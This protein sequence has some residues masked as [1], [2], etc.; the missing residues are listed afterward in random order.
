MRKIVPILLLILSFSAVVASGFVQNVF[1]MGCPSPPAPTC[2]LDAITHVPSA[3]KIVRVQVGASDG[4]GTYNLNQ[5]F[6]YANDTSHT[7][8]VLD[9]SFIGTASGMRYTFSGW[10]T[11]GPSGWFQFDSSPTMAVGPIYTNYTVAQC[12]PGP[13]GQN[14][15]FV[16]V[17]SV[18]PPLGCKTKCYLD[19]LTNVPTADGSVMVRVDSN[20]PV[21]LSQTFAFPN[22]TVHTI[23]VLNLTFTGVSS[24]A[25]YVWKQWSCACSDIPI[26]GS[27]TLTTPKMY[28]NDTN[29][30]GPYLNGQGA[31]TAV[32]DKQFQLTLNFLDPASPAQPVAP[33]NWLTIKNGN[34]VLNL[35]SYS[36]QWTSA[37]LWTVTDAKWEGVKGMARGCP[38][39]CPTIDLTGGS[40][41]TAITLNAYVASIKIV[42]NANNLVSGATVIVVLDNSTTKTFTTDSSGIVQLGHVPIGPYSVQVTYQNQNVGNWQT[43]ASN[44]ATQPL[45]VTVPVGSAGGGNSTAVSSI[46]L[47]TIFGL[48]LFLILLAIKVRKAPPAPK[49]E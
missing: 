48:A 14:C 25:K 49:I 16:A 17:F 42:D 26:T 11:Y 21:S 9:T 38:T 30:A 15:P 6:S 37:L 18:S 20:S 39:A 4:G 8:T 47:L 24:G 31:L 45:I 3:D 2:K 32:F 44:P 36:S 19:V 41:T 35:T 27:T 23:Q 13:P 40:L 10:Y 43:D 29:P 46:V 28:N 5:T 34:T 1:A 12:Q 7:I 22:G 33:P